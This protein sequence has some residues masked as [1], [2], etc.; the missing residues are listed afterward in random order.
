MSLC[1][2]SIDRKHS[3]VVV[4]L[5]RTVTVYFEFALDILAKGIADSARSTDCK[6]AAERDAW[7]V[8]LAESRNPSTVH[9]RVQ[10]F[11]SA[12]ALFHILGGFDEEMA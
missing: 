8:T 6:I 3:P 10:L 4:Y 12:S 9:L 1:S 7:T 5:V 2:F 11:Q